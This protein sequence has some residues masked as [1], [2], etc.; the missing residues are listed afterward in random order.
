MRHCF[1]WADKYGFKG[2]LK[3]SEFVTRENFTVV[4]S[5]WASFVFEFLIEAWFTFNDFGFNSPPRSWKAQFEIF[6][7]VLLQ[8]FLFS[9]QVQIHFL[10]D[11]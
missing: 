1:K 6:S 7:D 5:H 2:K 9:S 10:R 8:I 3:P 4:K 11:S